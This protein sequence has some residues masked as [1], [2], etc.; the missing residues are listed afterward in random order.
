[1]WLFK[2]LSNLTKVNRHFEKCTALSLNEIYMN[3]FCSSLCVKKIKQKCQKQRR[4]CYV[5]S[6]FTKEEKYPKI[7]RNLFR[8]RFG[9]ECV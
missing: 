7:N 8:L 1:M 4:A 9:G 3:V 6:K 5:N 2:Y